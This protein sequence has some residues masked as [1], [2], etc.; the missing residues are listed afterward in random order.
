MHLV[1]QIPLVTRRVPDTPDGAAGTVELSRAYAASRRDLWE[2]VTD[3]SRLENWFEPVTRDGES[4][5]FEGGVRADILECV[6]E[7][8]LRLTWDDG[9]P[10]TLDI[11]FEDADPGTRLT[12]AHSAPRD[13]LW[14]TY[15]PGLS[16]IGWDSS[17]VSLALHL[18]VDTE[19][20][21]GE[22]EAFIRALAAEWAGVDKQQAQRTIEFYL[23]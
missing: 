11:R 23:G 14:E 12:L 10:G 16:G 9:S 17:L 5:T 7:E 2:A 18:A 13:E 1:E 6:E 8:Y 20:V 4:L 15:G 19:A 3:P 21:E 22:E